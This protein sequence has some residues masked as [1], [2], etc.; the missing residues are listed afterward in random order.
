MMMMMIILKGLLFYIY[1]DNHNNDND[2]DDDDGDDDDDNHQVPALLYSNPSHKEASFH[3]FRRHRV[4]LQ[5]TMNLRT[6]NR[7]DDAAWSIL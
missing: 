2:D 4:S 5:F 1:D 7:N 3:T 6:I